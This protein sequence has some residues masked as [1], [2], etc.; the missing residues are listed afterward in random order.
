M[1]KISW[2]K[3]PE[4]DKVIKTEIRKIINPGTNVA[5]GDGIKVGETTSTQFNTSDYPFDTL[6]ALMVSHWDGYK[7]SDVVEYWEG[8]I[9]TPD[10]TKNIPEAEP[11]LSGW[12]GTLEGF[13]V[14]TNG[15]TTQDTL[16]FQDTTAW[17]AATGYYN[18]SG[19]TENNRNKYIY[20]TDVI[21]IYH[22][23]EVSL[24]P[25]Y[26]FSKTDT[27]TWAMLNTPYA[28]QAIPD[29]S[30]LRAVAPRVR[31]LVMAETTAAGPLGPSLAFSGQSVDAVPLKTEIKYSE[32][33]ATWT[34]WLLFSPG[35]T[36]KFRYYQLRFTWLQILPQYHITINNLQI[37]T[38]RR[39]KKFEFGTYTIDGTN[40]LIFN[41]GEKFYKQPQV[42]LTAMSNRT[43]HIN[44]WLTDAN[45]LYYGCRVDA[46]NSGAADVQLAALGV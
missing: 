46:S 3:P 34:D 32:D 36:Y 23:T 40:D 22:N 39:N 18:G 31:T 21:D 19:L 35:S 11:D 5:W 1:L 10:Q 7:W 43:Y 14:G 30:L 20:T 38:Y 33:N 45:G 4:N 44:T 6:F 28:K 42:I 12:T 9:D 24:K 13:T 29:T 25:E 27:F 41:F 8:S 26:S 16:D 2:D 15:I 17:N 37:K